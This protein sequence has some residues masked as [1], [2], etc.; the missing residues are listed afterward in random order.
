MQDPVAE[1]GSDVVVGMLQA[2]GVEH[3][4]LNPGASF[5]GIHDSLV[6]WGGNRRPR[7]VEATH[8]AIAVAMAHGYAAATGRPGVAFV[9]DVVGLQNATIAIY[10]A[11]LDRAPVLVIGGT[12][13]MD[14]VDRRPSVDWIHTAL[15]QGNLV[16]DFTKWDDQPSSAAAI[17]NS[18]I[19][20]HHVATSE[21][22]GPVYLCYDA[23]LQERRLE[24]AV[25]IPDLA[26]YPRPTR[27]Q[28]DDAAIEGLAGRLLGAERPVLIAEYA[29]RYPGASEALVELADLLGA[30]V[31]GRPGR[32]NVPSNHPLHVVE[33]W[34]DLVAAADVILAIEVEDL[35]GWFFTGDHRRPQPGPKPAAWLAHVTLGDV[36]IGSWAQDYQE[37]APLDAEIRGGAGVVLARLVAL[38]RERITADGRSAAA[39]RRSIIEPR[40]RQVRT[41]RLAEA[42]DLAAA[43]PIAPAH[44]ALQL[45]R[46][47][48]G[49]D[50]TIAKAPL[51]GWFW[52]I[53]EVERAAQWV[54][55]TAGT[56]IGTGSAFGLGVA[57]SHL[58]DATITV[59]VVGDGDFLYVPSTLWTAAHDRLPILTIVNNNRSYGNSENHGAYLARQRGRP[60]ETS[61]VGT[62]LDEPAT[63]F[64]A[65]ARS[66]GIHAEG[67]IE[68]PADLLPALQR[69]AAIVGRDRR[70]AL[71]DVVC[72]S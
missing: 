39:A 52:R 34:K 35:F 25:P 49:Y 48:D 1:Y 20:A 54:G 53:L 27:I 9:H 72:G 23:G 45:R 21:P 62:R 16:R 18:F 71:V 22:A 56:T 29:G 10:E 30:P 65:L 11:W 59:D 55:I 32:F 37:L 5:R 68:N 47:L 67:P 69:A 40:A 50:W 38:V 36:L 44:L 60:V 70:P 64:A 66:F 13:P 2:F 12:G 24:A 58:D 61:W 57:L 51:D 7:V 15:V 19:R 28:A 3:A 26:L 4:I 8:E 17:P 46:A 43:V 6:N 14:S 33:G 31:L 63:D 41:E 42:E